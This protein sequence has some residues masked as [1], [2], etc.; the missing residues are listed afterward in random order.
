MH[1]EQLLYS[2]I[3][4]EELIFRKGFLILVELSGS[5][6]IHDTIFIKSGDFIKRINI[7]CNLKL[8]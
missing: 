7:F 3:G 8:E 6:M 2:V 4:V 1:K 5:P